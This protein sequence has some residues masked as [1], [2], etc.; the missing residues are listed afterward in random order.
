[1]LCCIMIGYCMVM[2]VV[3]FIGIGFVIIVVDCD[4]GEFR[5]FSFCFSIV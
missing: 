2:L 1:M 3:V 4:I 5:C